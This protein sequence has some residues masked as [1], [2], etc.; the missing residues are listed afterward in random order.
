MT[1]GEPHELVTDGAEET[2]RLGACLG[3]TARG[4]ELLG[5]VGDLGAGKTCLVRGVAAGLGADPEAVHSPTF[6]IATEYRGGRLALHHVDLYRLASRALDVDF[7]R[8]DLFGPGVA[9]VEWFDHLRAH[10]GE[11]FLESTLHWDEGDR[12]RVRFEARGPRHR[13]WL[14]AALAAHAATP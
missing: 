10:A 6:V 9:C 4:G 7:L 11:E 2:E 14:R 12:R 5:L 3:R 1:G 8:E 13:L